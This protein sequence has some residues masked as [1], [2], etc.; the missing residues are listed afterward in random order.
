MSNAFKAQGTL[1]KRAGTTIAEV[2]NIQRSGS[3]ADLADVTNMD[4][5]GAYREYLPTLLDGGEIS[6]TL[7]YLG[8][9]DATQANLQS[10]FDSQSLQTWT[11]V[12]PG[13]KGTWT[14]SAYVTDVSFNLPHDKQ[15]ELST[16][17]KITGQP[18]F[19]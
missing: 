13:G 10:D 9:A 7:N 11:I 2:V 15:A 6:A 3:K 18:T 12:L 1:L 16:K 4:S 17:L 19:A 8:N 14:F 5:S